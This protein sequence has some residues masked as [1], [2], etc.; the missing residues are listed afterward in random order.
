MVKMQSPF[1]YCV[2][3]STLKGPVC[4]IEG[5]LLA[6]VKHNIDNFIL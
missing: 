4:W 5:D 2:L 1:E 6:D 3:I